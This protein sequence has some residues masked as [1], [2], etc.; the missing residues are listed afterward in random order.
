MGTRVRHLVIHFGFALTGVVTTL[1]GPMIPALSAGWSLDDAHAGYLFTAQFAGSLIGLGLSSRLTSRVGFVRVLV[2][3]FTFMAVGVA[4]LAWSGYAAGVASVLCYGIGLGITIPTTNLMVSDAN[5]SRRAAALNLLNFSWCV[6]AVASPLLIGIAA[7]IEKTTSALTGLSIAVAG[8]AL[9]LTRLQRGQPTLG[10]TRDVAQGTGTAERVGRSS[11][12]PLIGGI[13]FLYV[14]TEN[15]IAGWIASFASRMEGAAEA[16]WSL[17]PSTFWASLLVGRLIAPPLLRLV[18]ED[19]L[20]LIGLVVASCGNAV[21]LMSSSL[22][23][24]L[25]GVTLAGAGLATVFPTTIALISHRFG[26]SAPRVAGPVFALAAI[27]GAT[28]PW[29]V[30][31]VSTHFGGLRVGLGIPLIC[32][33]IMIALQAATMSPAIRESR[34]SGS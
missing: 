2:A 4:G 27:G 16:Y 23:G 5:P 29:T 17:A 14:G 13:A 32:T 25:A 30:G 1:L 18:S 9:S 3:G 21:L 12:V 31:W 7:G 20:V 15:A 10:T 26:A 24:L 28:L 8:I 19:K 6:G 34:Y 22:T 11:L 33:L